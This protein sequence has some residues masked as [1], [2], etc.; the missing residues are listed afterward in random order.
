MHTVLY[1]DGPLPLRIFESRYLDMVSHCLKS[2][3]PFGVLLIQDG[4]ETGES[5]THAVGTL[6]RIA[7]WH[8]GN[9]G[10][11]GV[12][13]VGEKRFRLLSSS[14]QADGLGVGDIEIIENESSS[15]LP[16]E[17][18][19]M[20]EILITVLNDLGRLYD[21]LDE[22]YEDASW[23]GYRFAEIL[24]IDPLKKQWCLETNDPIERLQV[25]ARIL[26]AVGGVDEL[27]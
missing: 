27:A 17:F 3:S 5:T 1:P 23:V 12:T 24:P 7:D 26:T 14:R 10:V 6:A 4:S 19:Q 16:R 9:D 13:A 21:Y 18:K 11:L 8:Q 20:A 25:L 2:Q 15:P 22:H